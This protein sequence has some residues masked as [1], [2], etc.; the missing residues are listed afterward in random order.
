[1]FVSRKLDEP[2]I[3]AALDAALMTP[4]VAGGPGVWATIK[5]P[6]PLWPTPEQVH[7]AQADAADQD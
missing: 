1:V 4:R 6:L 7:A 5:D 2:A 3:R